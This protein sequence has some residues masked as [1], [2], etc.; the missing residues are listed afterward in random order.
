LYPLAG[1]G[2]IH[3]GLRIF[4]HGMALK[5]YSKKVS[6]IGDGNQEGLEPYIA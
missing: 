3:R 6:R 2:N 4:Q 5:M 1:T